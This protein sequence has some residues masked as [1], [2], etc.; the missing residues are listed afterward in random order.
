MLIL[1]GTLLF[2]YI[3][4]FTYVSINKKKI[5]SQV[6][7]EISKKIGGKVSIGNVDLSFFRHFPKMSVALK[8]VSITDSM[9]TSHGHTFFKAD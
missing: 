3:I 4:A 5:I 9:F 1:L 8:Q 7:A 2:L 6:T